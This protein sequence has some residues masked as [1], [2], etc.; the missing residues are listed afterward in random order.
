MTKILKSNEYNKLDEGLSIKP[1]TKT[2]LAK[3]KNDKD[4]LPQKFYDILAKLDSIPN[5]SYWK[6]VFDYVGKITR[7]NIAL[8]ELDKKCTYYNYKKNKYITNM[9]FDEGS[10]PSPEHFNRTT[11]SVKRNKKYNILNLT[12]GK[13]VLDYWADYID[14]SWVGDTAT[15]FVWDG[16]K[17]YMVGEDGQFLQKI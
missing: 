10:Q 15:Y 9:W 16:S 1:V 13:L 6:N 2:R 3:Y 8:V 7:N 12:N 11:V 4:K 17:K 14:A 5:K